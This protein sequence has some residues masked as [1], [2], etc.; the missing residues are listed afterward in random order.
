MT[1]EEL[2][3]LRQ[4]I[5]ARLAAKQSAAY[6][7]A[8]EEDELIIKRKTTLVQAYLMVV[9]ALGE[10]REIVREEIEKT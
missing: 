4:R 6:D 5:A 3:S 10:A 9:N 7:T 2:D 1:R 8:F